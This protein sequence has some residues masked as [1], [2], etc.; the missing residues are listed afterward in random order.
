MTQSK[1]NTVL[2]MKLNKNMILFSVLFVTTTNFISKVIIGPRKTVIRMISLMTLYESKEF[3]LNARNV[4]SLSPQ[5][6]MV[7]NLILD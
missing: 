2:F 5:N 6:Y 1:L 4:G 3:G 7:L